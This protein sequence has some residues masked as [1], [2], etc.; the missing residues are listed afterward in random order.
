MLRHVILWQLKDE[1]TEQEKQ[2]VKQ[3]IKDGLE[4][5]NGRIA[6]LDRLEVHVNGLPTSTADLML[7]VRVAESSFSN[8][9]AHPEHKKVALEKIRPYVKCKMVL[10][11]VEI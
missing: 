1:L 5:L 7:D 4:N 8:Y 6:G 2:K 9:S 3:E 10:D 11:Y